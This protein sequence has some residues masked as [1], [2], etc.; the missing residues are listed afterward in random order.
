MGLFKALILSAVPL[1][2]LLIDQFFLLIESH[3]D[4]TQVN[5]MASSQSLPTCKHFAA[6]M[7][8]MRSIIVAKTQHLRSLVRCRWQMQ[9]HDLCS[10]KQGLP[11]GFLACSVHQFRAAKT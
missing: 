8:S 1:L 5:A 9:W 2:L 4:E 6:T 3:S 10:I 7:L 11:A